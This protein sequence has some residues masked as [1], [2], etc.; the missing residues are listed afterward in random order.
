MHQHRFSTNIAFIPWNWR[1]S[2]QSVLKLFQ[3]HP[4]EYS[5]SVHG[6]DH[7]AGEFGS[8]DLSQIQRRLQSA[9]ERMD[10]HAASTGVPHHRVMVF[11]QG[12]FSTTAMAALKQS[13]FVG[14]VNTE[15]MSVDAPARPL[16]VADIWDVAIMSYD[17]FP[18]FTRRY[19]WQEIAN[20]AFDVLL[21]KPCLIVIHHDFCRDKNSHLVEFID[22]LNTQ[23]PSLTWRGLGEVLQNSYRWRHI[24]SDC[25]EIEMYAGE[26]FVENDSAERLHCRITRRNNE[27]SCVREVVAGKVNV[28]WSHTENHL[29]F[30]ITLEPGE[31]KLI[32]IAFHGA[33]V[34]ARRPAGI[35]Y[36]VKTAMRRYLS[37]FRDDYLTTMKPARGEARKLVTK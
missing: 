25:A 14:A 13:D 16:R 28:P 10:G 20:F 36:R 19:P 2:R 6:C 27:P 15:V 22:Q 8:T 29:H 32:R 33:P 23:I 17:G 9:K 12:V 26:L 18:I 35:K 4:K 7:T 31:Q 1:R 3:D 37:E 30:E 21:G 24:T 11:P 34:P 5:L